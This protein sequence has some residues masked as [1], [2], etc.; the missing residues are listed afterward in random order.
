M[1]LRFFYVALS[2]V[3]WPLF[4]VHDGA[5]A[6]RPD[7]AGKKKTENFQVASAPSILHCAYNYKLETG[8]VKMWKNVSRKLSEFYISRG[9]SISGKRIALFA[10]KRKTL[11]QREDN[12]L[13]VNRLVFFAGRGLYSCRKKNTSRG[14]PLAAKNLF[15]R[16][17][18]R[19]IRDFSREKRHEIK[20]KN[21]WFFTS[22]SQ[23]K[24]L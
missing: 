18:V 1:F 21:T 2:S 22:F 10:A 24:N 12:T 20:G 13:A 6:S 4:Q 5:P 9:I 14:I 23:K 3:H 7:A 15:F 17:E 11:L 19:L 16:T 8:F